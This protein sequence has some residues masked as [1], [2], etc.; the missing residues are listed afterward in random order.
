MAENSN[1]SIVKQGH[2][3]IKKSSFSLLYFSNRIACPVLRF[4][5]VETLGAPPCNRES[6]YIVALVR[7]QNSIRSKTN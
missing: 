5:D 2:Y 4:K 7:C 6:R 1:D 3:R